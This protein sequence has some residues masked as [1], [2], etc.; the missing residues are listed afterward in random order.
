MC[1]DPQKLG[2]KIFVLAKIELNYLTTD[3]G[4]F[5]EHTRGSRRSSPARHPQVELL[6]AG[7]FTGVIPDLPLDRFSHSAGTNH[8]I[9][10][11]NAAIIANSSDTG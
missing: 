4:A 10:G 11:P 7:G 1:V 5:L 8:M 6:Y 3:G 9:G 2:L